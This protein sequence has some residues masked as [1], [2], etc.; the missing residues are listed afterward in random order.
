M[1]RQTHTALVITNNSTQLDARQSTTL[2]CPALP[3]AIC[4]QRPPCTTSLTVRYCRLADVTETLAELS[5]VNKAT[6]IGCLGNVPWGIKKTSFTVIIYKHS[7]SNPANL[8]K[9]SPVD[10][11]I[12]GLTEIVKKETKA[13]HRLVIS[14]AAARQTN[15]YLYIV[16]LHTH[17]RLTARVGRYQKKHSLTPI[18]IIKHL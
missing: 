3:L 14:F 13:E 10:S 1:Q 16:P 5:S 6:K 18:L 8:V 4:I 7:S 15:N 9:I 12:T 17:N 2:A 11:E